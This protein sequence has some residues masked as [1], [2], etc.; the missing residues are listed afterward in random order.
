METRIKKWGNSLAVRI[1]LSVANQI[2]LHP[3]LPVNLIINGNDL[4]ISPIRQALPTLEELLARV[5]DDNRH[6]EVD[7]GPSVGKEVW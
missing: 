7:F 4:T 5:T 6:E 2:D 1:P 3:D